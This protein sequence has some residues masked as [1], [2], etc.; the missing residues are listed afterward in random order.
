MPV[1]VRNSSKMAVKDVLDRRGAL[2]L[3]IPNDQLLP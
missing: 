2:Q 3:E 1:D